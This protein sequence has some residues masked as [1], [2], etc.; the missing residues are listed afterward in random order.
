MRFEKSLCNFL[1]NDFASLLNKR[2]LNW[3]TNPVE[4][5]VMSYGFSLFREGKI[6]KNNLKHFLGTY[7]DMKL[8]NFTKDVC[9]QI[10]R[11]VTSLEKALSQSK[12]NI[13]HDNT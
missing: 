5:E 8:G 11:F 10:E 3:E 9:D 4:P 6:T 7:M 13:E 1:L 12:N 2:K